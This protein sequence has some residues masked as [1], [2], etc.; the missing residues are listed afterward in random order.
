MHRQNIFLAALLIALLITIAFR[1]FPALNHSDVLGWMYFPVIVATVLMSGNSHSPSAVAG[2]TTFIVYTLIYW[3]FFFVVYA[4]LLE[5]YLVRSAFRQVDT[6]HRGVEAS[7]DEVGDAL[8]SFGKALSV[9]EARRRGHFFLRNL[10]AL[11]LDEDS[12]HLGAH[13]LANLGN[14]RVVKAVLKHFQ[15]QLARKIGANDAAAFINNLK[16]EANSRS[17]GASSA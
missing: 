15:T 13:A 14:E 16:Q 12:G 3:G 2:W 8:R 11:N 9:I 5:L 10:E 1:M 4:V 6:I 17:K 7:H